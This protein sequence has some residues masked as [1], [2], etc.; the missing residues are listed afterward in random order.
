M[1]QSEGG[2]EDPVT[3]PDIK[4]TPQKP[5]ETKPALTITARADAKGRLVSLDVASGG[6][7]DPIRGPAGQNVDI[8][9]LL[10]QLAT[11]LKEHKQTMPREDRLLLRGSLSLKWDDTMKVLDTC[12][13]YKDKGGKWVDLFPKVE[14]D[15]IR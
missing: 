10:G 6:R 2:A 5:T 4:A 9:Y 1:A 11:K 7:T 12:R 13:K 15:L 14:M 8:E 3:R